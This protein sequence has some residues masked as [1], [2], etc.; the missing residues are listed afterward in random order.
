MVYY[1]KFLINEKRVSQTAGGHRLRLVVLRAPAP[2]RGR[3]QAEAARAHPRKAMLM[4][5]HRLCLALSNVCL[6]ARPNASYLCLLRTY[7]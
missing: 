1:N 3:R 6:P 2:P 5:S 4:T 7:S